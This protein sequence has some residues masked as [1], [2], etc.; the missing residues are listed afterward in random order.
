M[1]NLS[2]HD[3]FYIGPL[4]GGN[5][6]HTKVTEK[7]FGGGIVNVGSGSEPTN[8]ILSSMDAKLDD[9]IPE[10]HELIVLEYAFNE[11][12]ISFTGTE[13]HSITIMNFDPTYHILFNDLGVSPSQSVEIVN[14]EDFLEN[15]FILKAV[16][17]VVQ[18]DTFVYDNAPDLS[19]TIIA[20]SDEV[21]RVLVVAKTFTEI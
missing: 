9:L 2:Q 16:D 10:N 6:N 20:G 19:T 3:P 4:F 15:D 12:P 5:P 1:S 14:N 8:T 18:G 11:L 13:I 17:P 21:V 7:E